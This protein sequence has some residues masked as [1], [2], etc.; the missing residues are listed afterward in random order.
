MELR[1]HSTFTSCPLET[2]VATPQVTPA[3]GP[4]GRSLQLHQL[5]LCT[6]RGGHP[7]GRRL[8]TAWEREDFPGLMLHSPRPPSATGAP[9]QQHHRGDTT[10][11]TLPR[12]HAYLPN[13]QSPGHQRILPGLAWCEPSPALVTGTAPTHVPINI[14]HRHRSICMIRWGDDFSPDHWK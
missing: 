14:P 3:R 11:A 5:G 9:P 7:L 2:S 4:Q 13:R 1:L 6:P 12:G 8:G 10:T